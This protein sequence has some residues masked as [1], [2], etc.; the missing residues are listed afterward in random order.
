M[1]SDD[2]GRRF[3]IWYVG[4][5]KTKVPINESMLY[6]GATRDFRD[7]TGKILPYSFVKSLGMLVNKYPNYKLYKGINKIVSPD[8]EDM[9]D[10]M[11]LAV[12]ALKRDD[13]QGLVDSNFKI[14]P[15]DVHLYR[16][17]GLLFSISEDNQV[18]LFGLWPDEFYKGVATHPINAKIVESLLVN[19]PNFW[20]TVIVMVT[21]DYDWSNI[22]KPKY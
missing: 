3:G 6:F 5:D 10:Y 14:A 22:F 1:S 2:K 19:R 15:S 21:S 9:T 12:I 18:G 4:L 11:M 20:K 16:R 7:I 8:K 13:V 17:V